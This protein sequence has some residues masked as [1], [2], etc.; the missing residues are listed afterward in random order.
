MREGSALFLYGSLMVPE[1]WEIVVGRATP[2]RPARLEDH[3]RRALHGAVYP[4]LVPR[5]G[6]HTDGC[7]VAG[8]DK[9]ELARLDTFEGDLY[10]RTPCVALC[11]GEREQA[12]V[13]VVRPAHR[14]LLAPRPWELDAFVANELPAYLDGC[15]LFAAEM[16]SEA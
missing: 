11:G 16:E 2:M 12:F 6:E 1:V 9:R 8:V 4:G 7:L 15:R 14:G 13:Y 3:V 5:Q 10:Q